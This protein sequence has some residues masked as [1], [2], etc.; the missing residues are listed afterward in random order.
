MGPVSA[1]LWTPPPP[2]TGPRHPRFGFRSTLSF[3]GPHGSL[4]SLRAWVCAAIPLLLEA[5]MQRE[6]FPVAPRT[7]CLVYANHRPFFTALTHTSAY[8]LMR[9]LRNRGVHSV[10][11]PLRS[12]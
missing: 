2:T 12:K 8:K 4:R 9:A 1:R 7:A 11:A 3:G 6:L 5:D 10:Y